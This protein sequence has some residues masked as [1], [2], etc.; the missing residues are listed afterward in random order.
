M[1]ALLSDLIKLNLE[2]QRFLSLMLL[3]VRCSDLGIILEGKRKLFASGKIGEVE[4]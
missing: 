4:D 2:E 1:L 3:K